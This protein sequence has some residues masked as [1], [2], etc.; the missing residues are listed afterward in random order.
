MPAH[1][2]TGIVSCA[3]VEKCSH[4]EAIR[5]AV[6]IP[7]TIVACLVVV[8]PYTILRLIYVVTITDQ[9]HEATTHLAAVLSPTIPIVTYVV[10][11]KLAFEE[12][13]AFL[14]VTQSLMIIL[15]KC[16]VMEKLV[17]LVAVLLPVVVAYFTIPV[18]TYVAGEY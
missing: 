10:M 14:V 15:L 17:Y 1:L 6:V 11:R 18:L 7:P 9:F 12:V 3:A 16:V 5:I 2:T 4:E 13:I 8:S